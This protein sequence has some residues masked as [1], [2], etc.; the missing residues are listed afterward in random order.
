MTLRLGCNNVQL[1]TLKAPITTAADDNFL[2]KSIIFHEDRL[3]SD[4]SHEISCFFVIF[5]KAGNLRASSA[6]NFR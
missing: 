4:N 3:S 5:E 1:L 2:K 6:V